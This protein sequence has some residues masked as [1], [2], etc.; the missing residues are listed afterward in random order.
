MVTVQRSGIPF[1]VNRFNCWSIWIPTEGGQL[2]L[3]RTGASSAGTVGDDS[4]SVSS[5][6]P[7]YSL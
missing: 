1:Q 5:C 7:C 6:G 4:E 3:N 2:I